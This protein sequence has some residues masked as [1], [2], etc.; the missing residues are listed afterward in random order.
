M[1]VDAPARLQER[2]GVESPSPHRKPGGVAERTKA[3]VLKTREGR[4]SQ[5]SNPC[6]SATSAFIAERRPAAAYPDGPVQS[7]CPLPTGVRQ[8]CGG[9]QG[10]PLWSPAPPGSRRAAGR[11]KPVP[12]GPAVPA[13][14]AVARA[15]GIPPGGGTGQARPLRSCRTGVP[16]G[17]P[18]HRDPAGRRDGTSPSPTVLPYGRPLRSPA[19]PGSRR[20]AGRDKPVPYG[21]AVPASLAVARATG[22]PPGGGTGQ[23]RPLRS[24]R[25]GV[26]CG[27]PRA[28][29]RICRAPSPN[30]LASH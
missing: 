2:N 15:T 24:C 30:S 9:S 23:A 7:A 18:R 26:P 19:P 22:I 25:T 4:P 21:P 14:L 11:D 12:Y 20:A 16:C 27:R 8:I 29:S 17:R 5:G 3:L 13:S 6:P 28:L 10:R 1:A